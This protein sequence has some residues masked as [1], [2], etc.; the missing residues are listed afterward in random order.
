MSK[1]ESVK[2][3]DEQIE[4]FNNIYDKID[5]KIRGV[6][7]KEYY[8]EYFN[9]IQFNKILNSEIYK[10]IISN[11]FKNYLIHKIILLISKHDLKHSEPT[12]QSLCLSLTLLKCFKKLINNFDILFDNDNY[13]KHL[14]SSDNRLK[15]I[16]FE[17]FK[18]ILYQSFIIVILHYSQNENV[19]YFELS[20]LINMANYKTK[21]K[22]ISGKDLDI[23]NTFIDFLENYELNNWVIVDKFDYN[24][25]LIRVIK[26]LKEYNIK[27]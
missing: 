24:E 8:N 18:N 1:N 4:K 21:C 9:K 27:Y 20:R 22:F 19:D 7:I 6:D 5:D 15:N 16:S 13:E 23:I 25:C 12:I 2:L 3:T 10:L 26:V 11:E 17:Q 14:K